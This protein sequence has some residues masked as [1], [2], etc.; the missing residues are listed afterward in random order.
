LKLR[1]DSEIRGGGPDTLL[2][3]SMHEQADVFSMFGARGGRRIRLSN[4]SVLDNSGSRGGY[5]FAGYNVVDVKVEQLV[6]K[7]MAIAAFEASDEVSDRYDRVVI[8]TADTRFNGCADVHVRGCTASDIAAT[9]DP[10]AAVLFRYCVRWSVTDCKFSNT[11]FGVQWWGGDSDPER[12]GALMNRR[13]CMY[14]TVTN[15][16]VSNCIAGTWGS[17]GS[18]V[19]ITRC[20]VD[21]ASDVGI[22]FE[23][24]VNCVASQNR[25]RNCVNGNLTIFWW[26]VGIS[27]VDNTSRQSRPDYPHLR[28][29]NASQG[30]QNHSLLVRGNRFST[31]GAIGVVDTGSGCV[32]KL[33]FVGNELLDTK[34]EFVANNLRYVDVTDNTMTFSLSASRPFYAIQVGE[35]HDSGRG[36]VERNTIES[37]VAQPKGTSAIYLWSDDYNTDTQFEVV[38]NRTVGFQIDLVTDNKGRNPGRTCYFRI[39]KNTFGAK[40]YTKEDH[41]SKMSSSFLRANQGIQDSVGKPWWP[42][43][44]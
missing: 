1:S 15:I 31:E 3:W 14:G 24:C 36:L 41:G 35:L 13:K 42:A 39:E 7:G 11:P 30:T 38:E 44:M 19:T 6:A 23:G 25:V 29:Y 16:E 4:F 20:D 43:V 18:D 28:V 12:D 2:I 8:D 27:L 32:E 17:M 26:N 37:K 10:R 40:S 34:V 9:S 33:D 5:V 21:T 22:D